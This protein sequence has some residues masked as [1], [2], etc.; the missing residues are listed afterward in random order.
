MKNISHDSQCLMNRSHKLN[1]SSQIA[2]SELLKRLSLHKL[3]IEMPLICFTGLMI[4]THIKQEILG[5]TNRLLSF[6]TA[7]TA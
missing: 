3:H 6:D 7:R 4:Q 5:R 2:L 1:G